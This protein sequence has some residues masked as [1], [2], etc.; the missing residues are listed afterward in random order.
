MNVLLSLAGLYVLIMLGMFVFQRSL[1]YPA[2]KGIQ[3]FEHYGF[4]RGQEIRMTSSDGLSLQAW[5]FSSVGNDK[6]TIAYFHGNAGHLGDRIDKI[7]AYIDAGFGLLALS[8]RGYGLSEGKASEQGLYIDARAALDY[9][10]QEHHLSGDMLILYGESLGTGVA[11]QMATERPSRAVVLEAPYTSI[12]ARA[13]EMY[14][15]LPVPLLLKDTFQSIDKIAN[16]HAPLLIFHNSGDNVVPQHHGRA[17]FEAA[18]EPKRAV[19]PV[20]DAHID[21]DWDMVVEELQAF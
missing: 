5:Y 4:S 7:R 2:G 21:F 11:V 9:L 13:S 15:W 12:V 1:L 6:P 20:S 19:W 8:Y 18:M 14:P 3:P 10:Q 16:I 17:L